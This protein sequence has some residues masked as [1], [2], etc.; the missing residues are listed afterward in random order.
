[1][2][3]RMLRSTLAIS[4]AGLV[5]LAA[6]AFA[7]SDSSIRIQRGYNSIDPLDMITFPDTTA[8][9]TSNKIEFRI[10]N[11]GSAPIKLPEKNAV[12]IS[13]DQAAAFSVIREPDVLLAR[14]D[15]T[16]FDIVFLPSE[17]GEYSATVTVTTSDA[18]NP[19][20]SFLVSGYG[21]Q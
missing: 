2:T 13:G 17:I 6:A 18:V 19:T 11:V 5:F 7:Q 10:S 3:L 12:V 14:N 20:F 21:T 1:M 9:T 4:A 8:G 16:Y 15:S